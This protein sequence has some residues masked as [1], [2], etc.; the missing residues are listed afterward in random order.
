MDR[1]PFTT[2]EETHANFQ[3][4]LPTTFNFGRD[5]V[6]AWA[7]SRPASHCLIWQNDREQKRSFTW[8][9]MSELTNRCAA[10]LS[11]LGVRKG[12]RVI[13]MLPR[14]PEWQIAMVGCFKLGAIPIPCIEMLTAKDIAYRSVVIAARAPE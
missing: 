8:S 5:V 2:W 6:D 3:V 4:T 13:V 11:A 10:A 7:K 9:E 14:I 12:D 1:I